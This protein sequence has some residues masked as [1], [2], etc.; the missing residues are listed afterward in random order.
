MKSASQ[1]P[2]KQPGPGTT[3]ETDREG[4]LTGRA[5]VKLGLRA[6]KAQLGPGTGRAKLTA[7]LGSGYARQN[8]TQAYRV[9]LTTG[10]AGLKA[11][12]GRNKSRKGPAGPQG[13]Q[14]LGPAGLQ[15]KLTAGLTSLAGKETGPQDPPNSQITRHPGPQGRVKLGRSLT[16]RD[17]RESL[18]RRWLLQQNWDRRTP[19]LGLRDYRKVTSGVYR[20]KPGRRPRLGSQ[21]LQGEPDRRAH[22]GGAR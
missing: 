2:G 7:G 3:G 20:V 5:G 21:G 14:E 10:P 19:K 6:C 13:L 15:A 16:L 9:K 18:D 8:R 22:L 11:C 1:A 4:W 12:R 17:Y